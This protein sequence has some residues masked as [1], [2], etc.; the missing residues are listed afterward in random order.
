[1]FWYKRHIG[2]YA[3][4]TGHLS[5]FEHGAYTLLL[6]WAYASEKP[7]PVDA[8]TAYR[9]CRA[10]AKSE[11]N[12]VDSILSQ[13]FPV[14][15]GKRVNKRTDLELSSYHRIGE[16][17]SNAGK[18]RHNKPETK[19]H[20]KGETNGQQTA[21]K[22]GHNQEPETKT[23]E[24]FEGGGVA[25][26]DLEILAWAAKWEGEIQSGTPPMDAEWVKAMLT[27]LNGRR[28]WPSDWQ[29]WMIAAWRTDCRTFKC[30]GKKNG[31]VS[32]SVNTIKL[33]EEED[34]LAYEI[35]ALRAT[36]QEVPKDMLERWK[37]VKAELET[38]KG[39]DE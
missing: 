25:V 17:R 10:M 35:N 5:L 28:E 36:N 16:V 39:S 14:V 4:D 7:L 26:G 1:M 37:A 8:E 9:I 15:E 23:Q 30:G 21:N 34:Q 22:T 18:T 32:A 6:D 11:K 20:T 3:R 24:P 33:S 29:R 31:A 38:M 27:K 13:F 19:A 12:A 2:D